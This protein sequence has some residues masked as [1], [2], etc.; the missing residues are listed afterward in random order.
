MNKRMCFYSF[1]I[2]MS[3][4][5]VAEQEA[6]DREIIIAG[7]GVSSSGFDSTGL[8]IAAQF[9]LFQTKA[10]EWGVRQNA[11]FSD[12]DKGDFEANGATR[13]FAD[14]HFDLTQFNL[15]NLKPFVGGSLGVTYGASVSES[16]IIGPEAGL[17]YYVLPKTF[18]V[19][20][21]S[22]QFNVRE[23]IDNGETFYTIG[24]GFNF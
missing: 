17:K 11:S 19:A 6:G 5:A 12:S 18:I 15:P 3:G 7:S 1:I 10:F 2:L 9:G 22:Y 23:N 4:A 24:M 8:G 16:F 13:A 20:Q 21:M 14:Y